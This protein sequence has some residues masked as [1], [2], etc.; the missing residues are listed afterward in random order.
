MRNNLPL[1]INPQLNPSVQSH[2]GRLS[3]ALQTYTSLPAH[4]APHM[5]TSLEAFMLSRAMD[6]HA[7][8]QKR[9]DTEWIHILISFLKAYVEE[10]GQ[11]LLMHEEDKTLYVSQLV[12]ELHATACQLD[13]GNAHSTFCIL[14]LN[15]KRLPDLA[16]PDH[17]AMSI[18][19]SSDAKIAEAEDGSFL[20]VTI[21]NHLP[22][23][24]SLLGHSRSSLIFIYLGIAGRSSQCCAGGP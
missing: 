5:W 23:V 15:H 20:D 3:V 24:S 22:C 19:V 12:H 13:T 8:L 10:L 14:F 16:H 11:E 2:R 6:T 17:P 21:Q 18:R 7:A 1:V 4:Y 9:K